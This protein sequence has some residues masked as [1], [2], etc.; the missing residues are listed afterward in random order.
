MAKAPIK[1]MLA[2]RPT[3]QQT[4]A[5]G[6]VNVEEKGRIRLRDVLRRLDEDARRRDSVKFHPD[7]VAGEGEILA[8]ELDG[9]DTDFQ[10]NAP[11]SLER[12]VT[13]IRKRAV[14]DK[15]LDEAEIRGGGWSFYAVQG[16]VGTRDVVL[17]RGKS[18]TWGLDTGSKVIAAMFGTQLQLIDRPLVAFDETADLVVIDD[19]VYVYNPRRV[20]GL[21]VDADAVKKRAPETAKQFD[22]NLGA[23]LTA[24]TR[25]A[26]ERVC[27]HNANVAR[28]V[29]R[30]IRDGALGSVTASKVRAALPDAGLSKDDFGKSRALRAITESQATTLI[31]IAAD[32]YYQPRFE[33]S[34]RR[35]ASYR[36]LEG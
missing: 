30:L 6:H 14:P 3:K 17:V 19:S 4:G 1:V 20:E 29:E 33:D 26:I 35:V 27:S 32:L 31:D 18:P 5:F 2:R 22:S 8:A 16:R 24:P 28:R 12:T 23:S 34:P 15:A 21:L 11:W 7:D 13:E 25:D 10:P 36:K 9:F